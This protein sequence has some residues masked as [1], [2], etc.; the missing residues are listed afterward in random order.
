[1]IADGISRSKT[2]CSSSR[3]STGRSSVLIKAYLDHPEVGRV[4]TTSRNDIAQAQFGKDRVGTYPAVSP[5]DPAA[6]KELA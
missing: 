4:V 2:K 1:M 5:A 3:F 6:I